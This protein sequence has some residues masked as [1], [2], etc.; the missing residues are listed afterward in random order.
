[1]NGDF[2]QTGKLVRLILRRERS[3]SGIWIAG[4]T[5]FSVALAAGM[6]VGFDDLARQAL[7]ETL[8]N[9]GVVAMMG[10]VYGADN[11]T[12]G[13][14][15]SNT[16]LLWVMLSVAVMNIFLVIRHTR[17]DEESGRYEIVRSLPSGR[18]ANINATMICAVII[19][20][21]MALA[22][23]VGIYLAGDKALGFGGSLLYGFVLAASGLVFAALAA[24]FAQ[25]SSNSRGALGYSFLS[26]GF[27]YMLR[28]AGD[29]QNETMSL[30]S[31]LGLALRAQVFV[32]DVW[33]PCVVLLIEAS[34]LA[35]IAYKLDAIRDLDQGFI[36]AKPG[37]ANA[38]AFLQS[39]FGL[40]F[41][42]LR[43]TLLV[44]TVCMF[45]LGA[46]YGSIL[47]DIDT[48]VQKSELYQTIIG[49]NNDYSIAM[50]F[51][52]MT[53]SET[54]MLCLVPVLSVVLR[55]RS[56]EKDGRAEQILARSVSRT[57]YL[58]GYMGLALVTSL[59]MQSASATG[60]YLTA[61]AVMPSPPEFSLWFL[62]K[63][64]FV[65]LPAI[66]LIMGLAIL[67]IGV[68]PKATSVIWGY[69][70][71]SFALS[72][73]SRVVELPE[74]VEWLNVFS[75]VPR[76]PIDTI[77]F[78]KLAGLTAVATGLVA[79][80]FYFYRKRDYLTA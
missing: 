69:S 19:N 52:T 55:L 18:L 38:S 39:A 57:G 1:M 29:I 70:A 2:A 62:L 50:M 24:L 43:N 34:S 58:A 42:L 32:L 76:L 33:W 74:P 64:G 16:V 25:L 31:P 7:A 17:A 66:W 77:D 78:T 67:L 75:H 30:V 68:L 27:F 28:A 53:N 61:W 65:Y 46:S 13:A 22:I 45:V 6:N 10:P 12:V 23:G 49:V 26:L 79:I 60:L 37:R 8:S 72:F 21:I 9:P 14:M 47:G 48:F 59:V 36:P 20:L 5:S 73:I 51:A 40:A 35:L 63:A 71:F 11:Y 3:V 4:L 54:A 80:G 44:W 41:R 56:E 15:Y